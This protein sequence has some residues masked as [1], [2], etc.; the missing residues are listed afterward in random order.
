MRKHILTHEHAFY[1]RVFQMNVQWQGHV[2]LSICMFCL[3]KYLPIL[4]KFGVGG[5]TPDVVTR[6]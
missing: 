2:H 4:I 1:T 6:F 3:Q 5:P